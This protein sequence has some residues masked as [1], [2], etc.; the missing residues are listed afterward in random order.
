M[1]A[2]LDIILQALE[3]A[4]YVTRLL[5]R[6]RPAFQHQFAF[7]AQG[8]PMLVQELAKHVCSPSRAVVHFLCLTARFVI[9]LLYVG[10][11]RLD[12]FL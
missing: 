1:S 8:G 3:D 11:V 7:P 2:Q 5:L 4:Y 9:A 12:F 6:A 10:S